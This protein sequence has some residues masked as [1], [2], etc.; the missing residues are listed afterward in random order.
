MRELRPQLTDNGNVILTVAK[1][2]Y[3][4]KYRGP[5]PRE[6]P[7]ADVCGIKEV[8]NMVLEFPYHIREVQDQGRN[9]II[10]LEV[11]NGGEINE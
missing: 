7:A 2:G 1:F 6:P 10:I 11:K 3:G 5:R 9:I 4:Y 8:L